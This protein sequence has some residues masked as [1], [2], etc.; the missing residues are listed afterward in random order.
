MS[1]DP[2]LPVVDFH[3]RLP[4]LPSARDRILRSMDA[5]GVETAVACAG[6]A[7]SLSE[8]SRQLVEGGGTTADL[9]NDF[10]LAMAE[11]SGG[12]LVPFYFGNP[13]GGTD[14]Y[15]ESAHRFRGLEISPAVHGPPLSDPGFADL[16]RTAAR[17][18]HSVYVVCF[19]RAG[20]R[21]ADLVRLAGEHPDV[22]FVMGHTGVGNIDLYGISLVAPLPNI[23]VET[24]GG[25]TCAVAEAIWVLGPDR[26]LFGSESPLQDTGV[27]LAKLD[28]L[29][30]APKVYASVLRGNALRRIDAARTGPAA[31]G[32]AQVSEIS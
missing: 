11:K 13:H 20:A 22:V 19:E 15:R 25:Y 23:L 3:V 7:L 18:G 1:R 17:W 32:P 8:L 28:A 6:G 31:P 26:V 12:R 24:S 29:D 2:D 30:L 27:E 16:I 9:D 5:H 14:A 10:V 21:V 4:P